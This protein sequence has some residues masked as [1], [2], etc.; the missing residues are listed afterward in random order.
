MLEL[1]EMRGE[2]WEVQFSHDGSLLAACGSG[3]SVIIWET[4]SFRVVNALTIQLQKDHHSGVASISW[5]PDDTKMVTCSQ[6]NFARLWDAKVRVSFN[7]ARF[8]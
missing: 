1:T 4:E 8:E 2:V 7:Y 5:S 6:D 3:D